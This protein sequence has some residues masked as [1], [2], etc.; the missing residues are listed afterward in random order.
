MLAEAE[1]LCDV[2]VAEPLCH[3]PHHILLALG[4]GKDG[5]GRC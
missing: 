2:A 1:L 5:P 3:Q 4:V